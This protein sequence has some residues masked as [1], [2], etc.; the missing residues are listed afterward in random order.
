MRLFSL[1]VGIVS[2]ICLWNVQEPAVSPVPPPPD[3][4]VWS[5]CLHKPMQLEVGYA[6]HGGGRWSQSRLQ[7]GNYDV[8]TVPFGDNWQ[9]TSIGSYASVKLT[10]RCGISVMARFP[11][12]E[13]S[14]GYLIFLRGP[15]ADGA[16]EV[17]R[18]DWQ[19]NMLPGGMVRGRA[20]MPVYSHVGARYERYAQNG[21]PWLGYGG[22]PYNL[23]STT[24]AVGPRKLFSTDRVKLAPCATPPDVTILSAIPP[25]K[26]WV[27]YSYVDMLGRETQPS[28]PICVNEPP[29]NEGTSVT[30]CRHNA[31]L[32][33][34]CCGF[35]VYA[36]YTCSDLRRQPVLNYIGSQDRFLWPAYLS[37][38]VLHDVR[39]DTPSPSPSAFVSSLLCKPQQ[40]VL[41][42]L[43]TINQSGT[44]KLYCPFLMHY[45]SNN[46]NRDVIG[47]GRYIH[48]TTWNDQ[49]LQTDIPLLVLSNF[50]DHMKNMTFE[51]TSAIAGVASND[52]ANGACCMSNVLERCSFTIRS[53]EGNG[54]AI[55]ERSAIWNGSHTASELT[56]K[57]CTIGATIP[58]KLEGNQTGKI[59]FV[60]NCEFTGGVG[61]TRYPADT[62]GIVYQ[63]SPSVVFFEFVKGV[64]GAF[65]SIVCLNAQ[66]GS[67]VYIKNL[68][69]DAGC[70]VYVTFSGIGGGRCDI[71]GGENI[72][73]GYNEWSRMV[74]A[75]V[76][77]NALANFDGISRPEGVSSVSFMLN[78]LSIIADRPLGE[79][80]APT[81]ASWLAQGLWLEYPPGDPAN[82]AYYD[83]SK[84]RQP[85]YR[86]GVAGTTDNS[87]ITPIVIP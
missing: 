21:Y 38:F 67:T 19:L 49:Q 84:K 53:P 82:P 35:Y 58:V 25:Q 32:P 81:E 66:S 56:L 61:A 16:S 52:W 60:D 65:R 86:F 43:N 40:D 9:S 70:P 4:Y 76:A 68:F 42:G 23:Q 75:P 8:A 47:K 64:N 63:C 18:G 27:S 77:L 71:T 14:A 33:H 62:V 3:G 51:S 44:Y 72:N 12:T 74:E 69:V 73:S 37:Q 48:T 85:R 83:F 55:E 54:L 1:L 2:S 15:Y 59:R 22:Y 5:P 11:R 7:P 17:D 28:D 6:P 79:V 31:P 34:G 29:F 46:W 78:Q 36:G 13:S 26:V 87:V 20:S 45:D 41:A 39:T 57:E 10:K 80:V 50:G 24:P 30:V